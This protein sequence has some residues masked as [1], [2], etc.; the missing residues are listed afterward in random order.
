MKRKKD[1]CIAPKVELDV[2][3]WSSMF[4]VT[5]RD[6]V[7]TK[8]VW[9]RPQKIA[10]L[11]HLQTHFKAKREKVWERRSHAFPPN[12]TPGHNHDVN[13]T[14]AAGFFFLE[15]QATHRDMTLRTRMSGQTG[16]V[17]YIRKN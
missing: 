3:V 16:G 5:T 10:V 8:K 1:Y 12:Y 4:S 15:K 17:S 6:V 14:P 13:V 7:L 9:E 11:K 2:S